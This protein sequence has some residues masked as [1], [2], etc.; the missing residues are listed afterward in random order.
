MK[1]CA[2]DHGL[3]TGIVACRFYDEEET[4][5]KDC[6]LKEQN[7]LR[8]KFGEL[9][10]QYSADDVRRKYV[11][12]VSLYESGKLKSVSL[13]NQT[14][15]ETPMGEFPAELV[16]FYES[17][18]IKRVFPLNGKLSGY[19]SELEEQELAMPFRFEF[20][21]GSFASRVIALH[22]YQSGALRSL[23][24]WP[25]ETVTL[26][27]PAGKI[28]VRAGFS[29]YENGA[30]QS[31]EPAAPVPIPTGIGTVTAFDPNVTGIHADSNS[32]EFDENGR[33]RSLVTADV[34]IIACPKDDAMQVIKPVMKSHPLEDDVLIPEPLRIDFY[35]THVAVI[36]DCKYLFPLESTTFTI[37][38]FRYEGGTPNCGGNCAGCSG[39]G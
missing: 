10:P 16:T 22:F 23:S 21:F 14:G 37:L 18:E 3:L 33:L 36:C 35:E 28:P 9:V 32:L 12:S 13:E 6:I 27:T 1:S 38:P 34:K 5:L 30:L 4:R 20:D 29:L 11:K 8:T 19:W 39:C 15:I 17:G 24:L 31:V 2:T 26:R 25:G 7:I